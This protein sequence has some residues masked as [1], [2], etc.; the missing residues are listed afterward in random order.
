MQE[1]GHTKEYAVQVFGVDPETIG[2]RYRG[3][4][5]LDE[6]EDEESAGNAQIGFLAVRA[7]DGGGNSVDMD[8]LKLPNCVGTAQDT[9][10]CTYRYYYF[11]PL[12]GK[13]ED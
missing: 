13:E 11:S 8:A 12:A 10:D 1:V 2:L 5:I 4:W 3:W 7:R 9:F 6:I